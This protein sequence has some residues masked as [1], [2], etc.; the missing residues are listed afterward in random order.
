MLGP[1]L[2]SDV[3]TM[4][5]FVFIRTLK[6][7]IGKRIPWLQR[8][9]WGCKT[10]SYFI[11]APTEH[12]TGTSNANLGRSAASLCANDGTRE[13]PSTMSLHSVPLAW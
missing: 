2:V 3:R 13:P 4:S 12:V 8:R 11:V 5:L 1:L 9:I 6:H 7:S 10:P